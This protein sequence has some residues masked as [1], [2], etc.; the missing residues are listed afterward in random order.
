[1]TGEPENRLFWDL[2]KIGVNINGDLYPNEIATKSKLVEKAGIKIVWIG[3]FEGFEDPLKVAEIIAEN[4][5]LKIGFGILSPLRRSCIEIWKGVEA[6]ISSH[7]QRF[8]VGIA[9]GKFINSKEALEK[10]IECIRFFRGKK[11]PVLAGVSSPLITRLSSEITDGI[12]INYVKP[13]FVQWLKGFTSRDGFSASYGPA[14]VLPSMFE[15]DLLIASSIVFL[16]SDRFI[17]KF[18]FHEIAAEISIVDTDHLIRLRRHGRSITESRDSK[19]LYKYREF[20]LDNFSIS[21]D[22]KTIVSRIRELVQIVDHVILSD[23]FFRDRNSIK[24]LDQILKECEGFL[25]L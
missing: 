18:G 11:V 23:P 6:L 16:S 1:L 22:I 5:D 3:E 9:P 13:E 12:L 7:G 14:L 8:Y 15:E 19:I 17:Q 21:G 2:G 10:T 25:E 24:C 20:L 4:T